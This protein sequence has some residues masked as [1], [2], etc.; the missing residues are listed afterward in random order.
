MVELRGL[1]GASDNPA[2]TVDRMLVLVGSEA[3]RLRHRER[4]MAEGIVR[5]ALP[6]SAAA[7]QSARERAA[8]P[9]GE[10]LPGTLAA[11]R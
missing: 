2:R 1:T 5:Q 4:P 10:L 11:G 7:S 6:V 3:E 9:N 8:R